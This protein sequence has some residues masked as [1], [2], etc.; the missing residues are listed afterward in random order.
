MVALSQA[1]VTDWM[2]V[3]T[4]SVTVS[5]VSFS[6]TGTMYSFNETENDV[7]PNIRRPPVST[8]KSIREMFANDEAI[9]IFPVEIV[10]DPLT[11]AFSDTPSNAS[12]RIVVPSSEAWWAA[13]TESVAVR[14]MLR[15]IASFAS[16]ST[17]AKGPASSTVMAVPIDAD[18]VAE[19]YGCVSTTSI[20]CIETSM[21]TTPSEDAE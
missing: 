8:V 9:R 16:M 17:G 3:G 11:V 14:V 15:S 5:L 18:A 13:L 1:R 7:A 10:S 4:H 21:L 6:C 19:A 2:D 20:A 12:Q